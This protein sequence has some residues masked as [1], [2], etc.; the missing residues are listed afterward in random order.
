[1]KTLFVLYFL[2]KNTVNSTKFLILLAKIYFGK[3]YKT[4][5][6]ITM[7]FFFKLLVFLEV[8]KTFEKFFC[9]IN[10]VSHIVK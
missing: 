2:V 4:K 1:M 7:S 10:T 5:S 6:T 3:S 8:R 9:I